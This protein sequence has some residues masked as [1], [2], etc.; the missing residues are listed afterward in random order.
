MRGLLIRLTS[1]VPRSESRDFSISGSIEHPIRPIKDR[2]GRDC[3]HSPPRGPIRIKTQIQFFAVILGWASAAIAAAPSPLTTLR[4]IHALSNAEAS[5]A[6]SVNFE[7]TVTYYRNRTER[8]LFVQDGNLAIFVRPP[9]D[10]QTPLVPGDRIQVRGSAHDSFRPFI[11]GSRITLLR[12]GNLPNP[13]PATFDELI[14]GEHDAQ[15][16]TA[17]G[18]VHAVNPEM[19]TDASAHGTILQLSTDGGIIAATID[20]VDAGTLEDL[21]DS[22]VEITGVESGQWDGKMQLIGIVLRLSASAGI[23]VLKRASTNPQSLPVTPMDLVLR[24]YHVQ[25]LSRRVRVRG[26]IT[27]YQPGAA[28]ILQSGDKSLWINTISSGNLEIGDLAEATGFPE[29]HE[30]SLVLTDADIQDSREEAPI[31]PAPASWA[32]LASR[33]SDVQNHMFDLVSIEGQVVTEVREAAQDEYVVTSGGQLFTA[34]YSHAD[35]AQN[36]RLP[37]MHAVKPGSRVRLTGICV[38]EKSNPLGLQAF[39]SQEPF[40]I[41]LRSPA[42]ISVLAGPSILSIRNLIVALGML[43]MFLILLGI[44]GWRL[45]RKVRRQTSTM[46]IRVETEAA[47]ERRRSQILEDISGAKPLTEILEQI[48]ELLYFVLNG[49]PCWCE[50]ADGTRLGNC[51]PQLEGFRV[52][53]KEIPTPSGPPIGT[54]CAAFDLLNKSSVEQSDAL[55]MGARLASLAIGTRRL[56]SDLVH[57]SEFDLLTEIQNRFSLEKHLD[58]LM[59][60]AR[61]SAGMF[62]IIYIDLDSFKKVNDQY[63]HHVGDLYLQNAA[64]RMKHQL[65]PTDILARLGGDEFAVLIP[66]VQSRADVE[67]IAQ[68]LDRCFDKPFTAHRHILQGSASVGIALYPEDATDKDTLLLKADHAMYVAKN[69]RK[70]RERTRVAIPDLELVVNRR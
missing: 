66:A 58:A 48:L 31:V 57:R 49:A 37:P 11:M 63:G 44:R 10:F 40:N 54:I 27:Y 23:K 33:G 7:A 67:E 16:V 34:V 47:L 26:T 41:L 32:Q 55:S 45:E 9:A 62:G 69:A 20:G 68:R 52:L 59:D 60:E 4:A 13:S 2:E 15:L 22:E 5:L 70:A 6:P 19:I 21:P 14:R 36:R 51:P 64:S 17:R 38:P 53:R 56:Y 28:V 24:S 39:H 12:H 1:T 46:A 65:R 35:I 3:R 25:N 50:I 8:W 29:V 42:D 30:G 43:L 18:V 61:R